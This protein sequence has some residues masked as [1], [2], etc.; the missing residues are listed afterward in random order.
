[1]IP[2]LDF[3]VYPNLISALF[4]AILMTLLAYV[5]KGDKNKK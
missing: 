1:V 5:L 3:D 2:I 4:F